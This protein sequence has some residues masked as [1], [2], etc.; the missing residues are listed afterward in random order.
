MKA[1]REAGGRIAGT[2]RA[3]AAV[4]FDGGDEAGGRTDAFPCNIRREGERSHVILEGKAGH[5]VAILEGEERIRTA[6]L[7]LS[8]SVMALRYLASS[9]TTL[10]TSSTACGIGAHAHLGH[11][12][13]RTAVMRDRSSL[14]QFHRPRPG[15]GTLRAFKSGRCLIRPRF[16]ITKIC[17]FLWPPRGEGAHRV[18]LPC[19]AARAVSRPMVQRG[20]SALLGCSTHGGVSPFNDLN[21]IIHVL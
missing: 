16:R 2:H 19:L 15:R 20:E 7:Q 17:C 12:H 18:A 5:S 6:P 8:V 4:V 10:S 13:M 9:T 3:L 11:A 1:A 21:S 14:N